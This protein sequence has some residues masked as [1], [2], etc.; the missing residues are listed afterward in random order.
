MDQII[1]ER[2]PKG[3]CLKVMLNKWK[4]LAFD[5]KGSSI[6][7]DASGTK[8]MHDILFI[9]FIGEQ[10]VLHENRKSELAFLKI[11][12]DKIVIPYMVLPDE[13]RQYVFIEKKSEFD[14]IPVR[15]KKLESVASLVR[16]SQ[17]PDYIIVDRSITKGD[18]VVIKN[19]FS[20]A[21]VI[22]AGEKP[23][24]A[25]EEVPFEVPS[26]MRA[27][28]LLK[29]VNLN[30]MSDNPVFLARVHLRELDL[31]K[32]NQLLLDFDLSAVDAEYILS[33]IETMIKRAP[34]KPEL[35]R[36]RQ[37]LET[38]RES[39]LFYVNLLSKNDGEIRRMID[40][41]GGIA[42]VAVYNTLI[43]KVR[44]Q[45]PETGD[46]LMLTEYENIL[47]EKHESLKA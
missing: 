19:R 26:D 22:L 10:F 11:I 40:G 43:A 32:T 34:Q 7:A 9:I 3:I 15:M 12:K 18:I 37:K 35:E 21:S 6:Y 2:T 28:D 38:L 46:Q 25:R 30:M 45:L 31:S 4:F 20:G 13:K 33:F 24:G 44:P 23:A 14:V 39:F 8:V 42:E 47:F 41:I 5:R 36:N 16:E 29:E 1:E 17:Q 27:T